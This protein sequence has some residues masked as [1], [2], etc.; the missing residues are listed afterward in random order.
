MK[1]WNSNQTTEPFIGFGAKTVLIE[2]SPDGTTWTPLNTV[3][4]AQ[5]DGSSTYAGFTVDMGAVQAKSVRLTIQSNWSPIGVQAT[6]LSEVRFYYVPVKARLP[7]PA[8]GATGVSVDTLLSWRAGREAASHQ[9]YFGMD[10][11]AVVLVGT[12]NQN[13]Y[14]PGPLN[15]GETYYWKI[16]EV[17]EAK[18]PSVWEGDVWSF[19]T[20]EYSVV[21]DFESY[22]NESPN[23]V[24]QTWIDGWGFS[25]DEFFPNGN[26]GNGT[27]ALVG[28]DPALGTIMETAIVHGGDQSMPVEYNNVNPPYYSEAERTWDQPQDWTGNGA[29]TLVLYFRGN[30][31][32]FLETSPGSVTMSGIGTDIWNAADEFRFAYKRLSGNGLV[33]AKVESLA[34]TDPWAKGGVMIRESLSP[35]SRYAIVLASPGNGVHFQARLLNATAAVSDNT[36]PA[37]STPEQNALRTPVWVKLER[38]GSSFSGF[39]ST[40]GVKWTT[41]SWSPQTIN[42]G[43][44]SVYIGLAVTS[45]NADAMTTAQFSSVSATGGVTGSWATQAIGVAQ[46][47]NTAAPIYVAVHDSAGKIKVISHPD[48]AATTLATWQQWRIAL[49]EFSS[50]GVKMTAV[51]KLLIGVGDRSNPKQDGA[52]R[53]FLDDI[54][55][56]HPAN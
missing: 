22:T 32:G 23:R 47:A 11:N 6:G 42:M 24:F 44:G 3:E 5:A 29:D 55:I 34:N 45:H 16:G 56:G 17:N 52:G 8:S 31:V 38:S 41:M 14:D 43:A 49:S 1:V 21:D 53:I 36:A 15:L 13:S 4:F 28:Y 33:I 54:G 48:P 7:Q 39:Y 19:S 27:G 50:A 51:K 46:P 18:T 9:V 35:D 30:P 2:C 12:V 25:K 20:S 37:V 40:D 10:P 26:P